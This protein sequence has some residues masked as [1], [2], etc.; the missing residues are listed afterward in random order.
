MIRLDQ[1]WVESHL[2]RGKIGINRLPLFLIIMPNVSVYLS[3][4]YSFA[5]SYRLYIF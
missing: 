2:K 4:V 3:F 5:K 1:K